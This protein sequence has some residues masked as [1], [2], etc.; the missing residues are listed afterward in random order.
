MEASF[1]LEM[2]K[3]KFSEE[4]PDKPADALAETTSR[5]IWNDRGKSAGSQDRSESKL[6]LNSSLV[7]I[8]VVKKAAPISSLSASVEGTKQDE[9]D[10][11]GGG[12]SFR[13]QSK[14]QNYGISID[15]D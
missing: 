6:L 14:C 12:S 9:A 7:R 2:Q 5:D 13:L 10:K 3:I 8:A 11:K 1:V 15:D 4:F